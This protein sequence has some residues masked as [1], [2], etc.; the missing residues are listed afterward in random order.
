[1][2]RQPT[3]NELPVSVISASSYSES[4]CDSEEDDKFEMEE[5]NI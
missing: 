4:S 2:M 3:I 1:M 5:I